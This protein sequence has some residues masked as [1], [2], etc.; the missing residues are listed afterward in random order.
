M[1]VAALGVEDT[2]AGDDVDATSTAVLIGSGMAAAAGV[3]SVLLLVVVIFFLF[4]WLMFLGWEEE[5][6]R[7]EGKKYEHNS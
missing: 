1:V 3:G 2:D 7:F 4:V 6:N 5:S